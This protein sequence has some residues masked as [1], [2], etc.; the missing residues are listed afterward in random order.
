MLKFE[1][2]I[3]TVC[4]VADWDFDPKEDVLATISHINMVMTRLSS[5]I[6]ENFPSQLLT[7]SGSKLDSH[8]R[9][10]HTVFVIIFL[11]YVFMD[12]WLKM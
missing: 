12:I 4:A 3:I 1:F 6:M 5:K 11:C 10:I 2:S 7:V 9:F 8:N